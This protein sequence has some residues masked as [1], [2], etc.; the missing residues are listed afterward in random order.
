MSFEVAYRRAQAALRIM[1]GVLVLLFLG[2]LA[3]MVA[4]TPA[5]RNHVFSLRA[6]LIASAALLLGLVVWLVD[7]WLR[8][9]QP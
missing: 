4:N 1:S 6:S 2:L 3:L 5:L 7:K 9:R 8:G